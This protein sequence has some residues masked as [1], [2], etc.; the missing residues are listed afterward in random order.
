[1]RDLDERIERRGRGEELTLL[2]VEKGRELLRRRLDTRP[3]RG[4][5]QG[6]RL[7]HQ[8]GQGHAVKASARRE[9]PRPFMDGGQFVRA[10]TAR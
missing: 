4:G 1:M 7:G 9:A 10:R 5:E 6:Q 3:T 2:G 8:N